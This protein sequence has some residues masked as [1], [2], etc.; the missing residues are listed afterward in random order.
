MHFQMMLVYWVLLA[1][2]GGGWWSGLWRV[3][4]TADLSPWRSR[5][6]AIAVFMLLRPLAD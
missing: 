4:D 1:A 3:L 5:V 2:L 6:A